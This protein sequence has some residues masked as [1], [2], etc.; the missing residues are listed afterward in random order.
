M[1]YEPPAGPLTPGGFDTPRDVAA[2]LPL[3]LVEQW[4]ASAGTAHD[5]RRL[6]A[7]HEIRGYSVVSDSAGLTRLSQRLGLLEV[8][9]LIDRPKR[10]LHACAQAAGGRAV[11]VWAADNAQLFHPEGADPSTLLSALLT[12]QDE[13][14]RHCLVSIGIGVH[15]GSFYELSGGLYGAEADA[16]EEF[17]ENDTEGGEIAV[18]Q[19]VVDRLPEGH[20]FVLRRK[21]GPD[22]LV[23]PVH[24]VVDGPRLEVPRLG[25]AWSGEGWPGASGSAGQEH[26]PIPYSAPFYADLLLLDARPGDAELAERLAAGHLRGRTVVLVE[27]SAAPADT[28]EMELLRGLSLS[29]AMREAGLRLLP[30]EGAVEIKVAGP[31][32][33][34]LFEEPAP[35]VRFALRLRTGLAEREIVARIGVAAGPVLAGRTPG[36]G[37]DVAGAPVNLA[38][39]MAQDLGSPG[40]VH[41]SEAVRDAVAGH[42]DHADLVGF[43]PVR[44]TV[45]GVEMTYYQG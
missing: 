24:Q 29:A 10:I 27:R 9:A 12:A 15:L 26:Y 3:S 44:R 7:P 30:S 17:A 1:A 4:R 31:L 20:P 13:I 22:G 43:E 32:G 37:W 35:A 21:D 45:S 39:K 41:L 25:E 2:G 11:G 40:R 16:A 33:I 8:L 38:S 5:A 18:T 19:A 23:G 6:L 28:P 34:Y 36:G 14:R 42:D